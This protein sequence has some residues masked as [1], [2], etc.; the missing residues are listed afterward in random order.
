MAPIE[1]ELAVSLRERFMEKA[2]AAAAVVT[3]ISSLD[4]AL[5]YDR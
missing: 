1:T 5:A 3:E 4:E 2:R